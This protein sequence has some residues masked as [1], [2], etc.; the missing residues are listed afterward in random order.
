LS[1]KAIPDAGLPAAADSS[2]QAD[3][4]AAAKSVLQELLKL[5]ESHPQFA[6]HFQGA[7]KAFRWEAKRTAENDHNAVLKALGDGASTP[8]EL[9]EDSRLSLPE[10]RPILIKL[11]ETGVVERRPR[12]GLA[13]SDRTLWIYVLK[14]TPAGNNISLGKR[15]TSSFTGFAD[16]VREMVKG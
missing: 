1:T 11:I 12:P 2:P 6:R 16:S 5:A 13:G 8:A 9:C 7:I 14:T 15:G 3:S 4:A 10:L